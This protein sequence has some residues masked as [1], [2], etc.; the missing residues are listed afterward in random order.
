MSRLYILILGQNHLADSIYMS[1]LTNV[2]HP[3]QKNT[4]NSFKYLINKKLIPDLL[5]QDWIKQQSKK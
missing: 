3:I 1:S 4:F 5:V 2:F